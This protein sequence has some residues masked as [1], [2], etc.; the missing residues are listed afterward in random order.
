MIHSVSDKTVGNE[1]NIRDN[2][3]EIK[4]CVICE[5]SYRPSQP[6]VLTRNLQ[7]LGQNSI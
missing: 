1:I 2:Y 5:E 3:L 4:T 7:K 6:P